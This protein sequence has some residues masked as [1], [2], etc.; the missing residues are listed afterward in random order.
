MTGKTLAVKRSARE[1]IKDLILV[2]L[3]NLLIAVSSVYFVIPMKIINGGVAGIAVIINKFIP[4]SETTIIYILVGG[5]FIIGW[6]FLGHRFAI[7]TGISTVVYPVFVSLLSLFPRDLAISRELGAIY[8]GLLVGVGIGLIFRTGASSGG[9]DVFVLLIN[10][11]LHIEMGTA[12]LIADGILA[13]L[14]VV[15]YGIETV[16]L[17]ILSV[18]VCSLT[19]DKVLLI[20]GE[21]TKLIYINSLKWEEISQAIQDEVHRGVTLLDAMGGYSQKERTVIMCAI[22]QRQYGQISHLIR[23]ID[24]LAFVVVSDAVDVSGEGFTCEVGAEL[25]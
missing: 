3:G 10:K 2:L 15:A 17:G 8:A 4:L 21:Q 5:L 6:I 14:G 25:P 20:G 24:P 1:W 22:S 18:I 9:S 7:G 19:V 23:R 16:L 11:Y 13:A 12:E